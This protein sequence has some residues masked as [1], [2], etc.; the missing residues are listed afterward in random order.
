MLNWLQNWILIRTWRFHTV[1]WRFYEIYN[2][3]RELLGI[4]LQHFLYFGFLYVG[5]QK[6]C[7]FQFSYFLNSIF[8]NFQFAKF[9]I[10]KFIIYKIFIIRIFLFAKV[11]SKSHCTLALLLIL[12]SNAQTAWNISSTFFLFSIF[13]FWNFKISSLRFFV[14]PKFRYLEFENWNRILR[15][16]H[17][18]YRIFKL[19]IFKFNILTILEISNSLNFEFTKIRID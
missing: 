10:A 17:F 15:F 4:F 7:I 12:Q 5:I 13:V 8:L 1:L 19:N 11:Q 6:F 2:Q 3:L 18:K 14:F 16:F 9:R